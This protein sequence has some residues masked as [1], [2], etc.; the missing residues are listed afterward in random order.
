M[1]SSD[2]QQWWVTD[3]EP[4]GLVHDTKLWSAPNPFDPIK[5]KPVLQPKPAP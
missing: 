3:E 5:R 1:P 4:E 2:S